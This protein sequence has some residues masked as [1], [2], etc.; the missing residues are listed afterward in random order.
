MK[1][2]QSALVFLGFLSLLFLI[3]FFSAVSCVG[4]TKTYTINPEEILSYGSLIEIEESCTLDGD[5]IVN[6][7]EL[8]HS[9]AYRKGNVFTINNQKGI[10]IDC[11]GHSLIHK[12]PKLATSKMY[13]NTEAILVSN[14]EDITI[15]NCNII[16]FDQGIRLTKVIDATVSKN[17]IMRTTS[18]GIDIT[19]S[20]KITIRNNFI[21]FESVKEGSSIIP[22]GSSFGEQF[23][24]YY[25]SGSYG[26]MVSDAYYSP[27]S[28]EYIRNQEITILNNEISGMSDGIVLDG[29]NKITVSNNYL[30]KNKF[31]GINL[32]KVEN[33]KISQNYIYQNGVEG[34]SIKLSSNN[35]I[36]NNYI[37]SNEDHGMH[38]QGSSKN[39]ITDNQFF[40]NCIRYQNHSSPFCYEFYF[41]SSYSTGYGRNFTTSIENMVSKNILCR[42]NKTRTGIYFNIEDKTQQKFFEENTFKKDNTCEGFDF[43]E[44]SCNEFKIDSLPHENRKGAS[45]NALEGSIEFNKRSAIIY[46]GIGVLSITGIGIIF[47]IIHALKKPPLTINSF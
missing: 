36:S 9:N 33:S 42:Q 14:S 10:T 23:G 31:K 41:V 43:C 3:E 37:Y 5:I 7:S 22:K 32:D 20:K 27:N 30:Y 4:K 15:K 16:G 26:I 35:E 2:R 28:P 38:I 25:N 1:K 46:G 12:I 19:S 13:E 29:G 24:E 39:T 11:N 17:N 6:S 34:V 18:Y 47:Y 21:S 44:K 8:P 45:G 40:N